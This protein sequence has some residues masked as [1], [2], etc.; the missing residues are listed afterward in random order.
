[1]YVFF[2]NFLLDLFIFLRKKWMNTSKFKDLH[3][4]Q[5]L[6]FFLGEYA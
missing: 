1:M 5:K 2:S 4:S 3:V 6:P